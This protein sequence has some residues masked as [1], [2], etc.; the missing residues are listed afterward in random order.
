MNDMRK[1]LNILNENFDIENSPTLAGSPVD[2]EQQSTTTDDEYNNND[3]LQSTLLQIIDN[4]NLLYDIVKSGKQVPSW[5]LSKVTR[6]A[7][8]LEGVSNFM[9]YNNLVKQDDVGVDDYDLSTPNDLL[10][11]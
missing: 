11:F 7:E 6:S 9:N 8:N 3:M 4:A 2:T 1:F 5:A 10:D